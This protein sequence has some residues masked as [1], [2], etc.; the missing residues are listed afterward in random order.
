[1]A[2]A[3]ADL[4]SAQYSVLSANP[5]TWTDIESIMDREL[6]CSCL[7]VSFSPGSIY[8]WILK[9]G[10]VTLFREIKGSEVIAYEGTIKNLDEVLAG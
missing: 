2:R 4:M 10:G 9:G 1:M 8:F 6:N 3:L 5:Q 7:C